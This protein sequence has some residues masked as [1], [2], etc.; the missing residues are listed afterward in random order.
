MRGWNEKRLKI[1]TIFRIPSS[2]SS[3][4]LHSKALLL[5]AVCTLGCGS[6]D[7]PTTIP[8]TG[9]VTVDGEACP[10]AGSLRF[11]PLQVVEGLPR[12]PGRADFG[13]D[14]HF[15]VTS[16]RDGDGLVPG[17]YRVQLECW[18]TPPANGQPGVSFIKDDF[19][20]RELTVDATQRSIEYDIDAPRSGG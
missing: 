3:P 7:L 9:T 4:H 15:R 1:L 19:A 2:P 5:L 12:R 10:A 18:Q 17:T 14:G 8:V 11:S 20:P 6:S 16:F 13:A